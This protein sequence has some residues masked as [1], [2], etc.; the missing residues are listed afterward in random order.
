MSEGDEGSVLLGYSDESQYAQGRYGAI[1]FVSLPHEVAHELRSELSA[2][3]DDAGIT[4]LR[5]NDVRE[6][7]HRNGI[8]AALDVVVDRAAA[9]DLRVDTLTWD[10]SDSRHAVV[11]RDDIENLSRLYFHLARRVMGERWPDGARWTLRPHRHDAV[12][13]EHAG[14]VVHN[15]RIGIEDPGG[16]EEGYPLGGVRTLYNVDEVEPVD[17]GD[18]LTE[19]ADFFA[20]LTVYSYREYEKVRAWVRSC[21]ERAEDNQQL[22][23]SISQADTVRIP[24]L[25]QVFQACRELGWPVWLHKRNGLAVPPPGTSPINFWRYEAVSEMDQAPVVE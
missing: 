4:S 11:G 9:G 19:V 6:E 21:G 10:T 23:G 15:S 24:C 25:F 2:L 7:R 13:W 18:P 1:S 20:G 22:A 12:D 14:K 8:P 5:W 3:M 16:T 17:G